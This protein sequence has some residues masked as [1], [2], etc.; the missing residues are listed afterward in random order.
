MY[1][2]LQQS[3]QHSQRRTC[4]GEFSENDLSNVLS[5]QR[6][7]VIVRISL[8]RADEFGSTSGEPTAGRLKHIALSFTFIGEEPQVEDDRHQRP[9]L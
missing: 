4:P 8:R 3:L 9:V 6:K 2:L 7:T 5:E 1:L